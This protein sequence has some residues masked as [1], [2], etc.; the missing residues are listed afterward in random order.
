MSKPGACF[1]AGH[2]AATA[3]LS[4]FANLTC[5]QQPDQTQNPPRAEARQ[6][7]GYCSAP[8]G[9]HHSRAAQGAP[10][11]SQGCQCP[12]GTGLS[13][14]HP[15]V[16][17]QHRPRHTPRGGKTRAYLLR[18]RVLCFTYRKGDTRT[19]HSSLFAYMRFN[20]SRS[21]VA[22]AGGGRGSSGD[23]LP[24]RQGTGRYGV[25][26]AQQ[27]QAAPS[28]PGLSSLAHFQTALLNY[29]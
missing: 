8:A 20:F 22:G 3:S 13:P 5:R 4:P 27:G 2:T 10:G 1:P 26:H 25:P 15:T 14:A 18:A 12:Q 23:S 16:A 29:I 11:H 6:K 19:P 24:T 21:F 28:A 17:P 7:N 9:Q